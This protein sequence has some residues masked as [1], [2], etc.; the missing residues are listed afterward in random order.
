[1]GIGLAEITG[2]ALVTSGDRT[3]V[4]VGALL[5]T[6]VQHGY[7]MAGASLVFLPLGFTILNSGVLSRALGVLAVVLGGVFFLFGLLGVLF[8]IQTVVDIL[9]S[10]QGLWWLAAGINWLTRRG[11]LEPHE[12]ALGV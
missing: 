3:V 5:I 8:S 12:E 9:L 7:G 2:F 11:G 6:G 10:L 4:D 1:M